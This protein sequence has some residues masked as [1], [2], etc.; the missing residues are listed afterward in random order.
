MKSLLEITKL[1]PF[2]HNDQS[3]LLRGDCVKIMPQIKEKS[4]DVIFADPPYFLSSGGISVQSGK[5]V[6]V[7]KGDWDKSLSIQDKLSFHQT[8]IKE[9]RKVLK[10]DG[11]IWISATLHSVYAIGVALELEGF[12]IIN[13]VI[14]RKTNPAPNISGRAF[15]HS[16][17]TVIWARKQLTPM[18]KGK[19][20]FAYDE[21]KKYNQGKQLKD[22]W[23][24]NETNVVFESGTTPK[25]EKKY[26]KHPT[27]K[28]ISLLERIIESSTKEG[29]LVLDPFA[30]SGTTLIVANQ[31]KRYAIGIEFDK[32]YLDLAKK[33]IIGG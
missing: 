20:Y 13:N 10:D 6:S 19:H 5:M 33:R 12:S 23:D 21:M 18:K 14:W 16:T 3:L 24:L 9:A 7:N 2:W 4:I 28:P 15:T 27:Q 30:G 29:E 8:W 31:L 25:R 26:G 17:E 11:T 22:F 1:K 32:I